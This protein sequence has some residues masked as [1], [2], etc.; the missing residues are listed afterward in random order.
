MIAL[1]VTLNGKRV[2]TAGAEDLSVL[3]AIVNAVGPLGKKTVK[4]RP[5]EAPDLHYMVGGLTSRPDPAKDVHLR[6]KRFAPLKIGDVIQIKVVDATKADPP[7][8]RT[9]ARRANTKRATRRR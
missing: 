4:V 9:K 5:N 3:N 7:K 8:F 2:C 6:W 1:K